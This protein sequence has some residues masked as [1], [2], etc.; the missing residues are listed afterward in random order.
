MKNSELHPVVKIFQLRTIDLIMKKVFLLLL[1][2][3]ESR[4][5]NGNYHMYLR[6]AHMCEIVSDSYLLTWQV[7]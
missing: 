6:R 4:K 5:R 2:A 7:R 1:A 3:P